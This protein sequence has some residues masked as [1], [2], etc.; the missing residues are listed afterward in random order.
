MGFRTEQAP[1][2]SD[3][4]ELADAAFRDTARLT[5]KMLPALPSNR[6][7]IDHILKTR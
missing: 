5:A 6:E 1:R 4:P 3:R 7:L 2:A